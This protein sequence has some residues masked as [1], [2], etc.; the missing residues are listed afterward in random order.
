MVITYD[1]FSQLPD[2]EKLNLLNNT[3]WTPEILEFVT[4]KIDKLWLCQ[5]CGGLLLE[6]TVLCPDCADNIGY[7]ET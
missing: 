7:I 2:E 1:Q 4:G 3:A 5:L 6:D